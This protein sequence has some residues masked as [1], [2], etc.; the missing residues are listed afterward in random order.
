MVVGNFFQYSPLMI[1]NFS[2]EVTTVYLLQSHVSAKRTDHQ[3]L[4]NKESDPMTSGGDGFV[5]Y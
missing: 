3:L 1:H 4:R 5:H 2:L